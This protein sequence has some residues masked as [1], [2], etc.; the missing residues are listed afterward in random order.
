[1]SIFDILDNQEQKKKPSVE[2]L[3]GYE[4]DQMR[5]DEDK[6]NFLDRLV[7]DIKSKQQNDRI[8]SR[9]FTR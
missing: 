2:E 8:R 3:Y 1:M 7:S 5:E 4:E 6:E 9:E